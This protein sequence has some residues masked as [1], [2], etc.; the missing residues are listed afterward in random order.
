[1]LRLCQPTIISFV[2]FSQY[3]VQKRRADTLETLSAV[4]KEV[5]PQCYIAISIELFREL[6]EI[7]LELMGLNLR[8]LYSSQPEPPKEEE[9]KTP[10]QNCTNVSDYSFHK[11]EAVAN[12]HRRLYQ[13]SEILGHG[14]LGDLESG[15]AM[16][17]FGSDLYDDANHNLFE[18]YQ[19]ANMK[20]F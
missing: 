3:S 12:V 10:G 6:A 13:F 14:V 19:T 15:C 20:L 4:L 17:S 9:S 11:M 18:S 1:M 8:R 7:H 2:I 16:S 5:R